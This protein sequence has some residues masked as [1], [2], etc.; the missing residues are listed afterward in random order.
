[1]Q[2][3]KGSIIEVVITLFISLGLS[4][5]IVQPIVF[6]MY[7]ISL[8]VVDN[9]NIAVIFTIVSVVRGYIMRR[10]FNWLHKKYPQIFDAHHKK[11]GNEN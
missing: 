11:E 1:M 8:S 9:T 6:D 7:N 10:F 3:K 4:I 5:L 2:S